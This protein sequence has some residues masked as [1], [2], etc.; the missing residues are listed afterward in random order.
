M[1]DLFEPNRQAM[2]EKLIARGWAQIGG[3]SMRGEIFWRRPDTALVEESEAFKQLERI[4]REEAKQVQ[5]G[6]DNP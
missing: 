1:S 3:K 2:R 4:E 6:P 5:G